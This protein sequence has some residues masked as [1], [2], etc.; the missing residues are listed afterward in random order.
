M[1]MLAIRL[2][3]NK[4]ANRAGAGITYQEALGVFQKTIERCLKA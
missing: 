3:R 1:K 2:L 4:A